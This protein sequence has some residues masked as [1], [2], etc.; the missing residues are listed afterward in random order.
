MRVDKSWNE[1]LRFRKTGDLFR[2]FSLKI[3]Y[4][5]RVFL[6]EDKESGCARAVDF[7]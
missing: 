7:L 1:E 3:R 4:K 5:T 6:N 2:L